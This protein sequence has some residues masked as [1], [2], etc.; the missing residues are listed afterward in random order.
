MSDTYWVVK[1]IA[2]PG[3]EWF[4]DPGWVGR[5]S[6]AR[7]FTSRSAAWESA[8]TFGPS[9]LPNFKRFRVVRVVPKRKAPSML[10]INAII[11]TLR[12]MRDA[13]DERLSDFAA[14]IA[15]LETQVR[16]LQ[17]AQSTRLP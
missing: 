8:A 3:R 2:D 9:P 10:D 14:R 12:A 15:V 6:E 17:L 7:R 11:P 1:D 16:S 5:R 4:A 13:A